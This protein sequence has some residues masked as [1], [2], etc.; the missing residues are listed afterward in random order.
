MGLSKVECL[1]F[2]WLPM[3]VGLL[4]HHLC[5]FIG[6]ANPDFVKVWSNIFSCTLIF[7]G[8]KL[9][10]SQWSVA[11]KLCYEYVL[12][13]KIRVNALKCSKT[14]KHYLFSLIVWEG[15]GHANLIYLIRYLRT[16]KSTNISQWKSQIRSLE[17]Q[18]PS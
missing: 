7:V 9:Q 5:H 4:A 8:V 14:N 6:S 15:T 13:G 11:T 10:L 17:L 3:L 16:W 12:K 2:K 18:H 1:C